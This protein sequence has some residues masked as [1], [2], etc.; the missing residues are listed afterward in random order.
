M[1]DNF[2]LTYGKALIITG[3]SIELPDVLNTVE[4]Y[5]LKAIDK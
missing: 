2:M 4:I 5:D 3:G 1:P